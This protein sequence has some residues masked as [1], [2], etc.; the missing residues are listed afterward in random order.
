[1]SLF[2]VNEGYL[3]DV[4]VKKVVDF[5]RALQSYMASQQKAL[6][7]KID[8]AG[9]YNDEIQQGLHAAVKDFKANNTW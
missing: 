4:D 5:E 6:L 1:V 7:E 8:A 3:D 2:A 9:D